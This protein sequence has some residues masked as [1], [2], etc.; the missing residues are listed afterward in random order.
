MASTTNYIS[1][2]SVQAMMLRTGHHALGTWCR[3]NGAWNLALGTCCL[4][5]GSWNLASGAWLLVSGSWHLA[6][7]S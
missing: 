1:L 3:I 6:P 2:C 5:P 7:G 4:A